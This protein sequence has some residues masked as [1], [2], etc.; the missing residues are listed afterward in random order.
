MHTTEILTAID[1]EIAKLQQAR[2][3]LAGDPEAGKRGGRR[4]TA[5]NGTRRTISE[6]GRAV[7]LLHKKSGGQLK[8]SQ[9]KSS[10]IPAN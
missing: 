2:R 6:E 4:Q 10:L 5:L 3:L 9:Q 8:G 7:S 1:D